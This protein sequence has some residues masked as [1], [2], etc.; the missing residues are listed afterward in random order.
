VQLFNSTVLDN[1]TLFDDT[2]ESA[3]VMSVLDDVGLAPWLA[4][5]PDGLETVIGTGGV[6]MSAGEAQLL[7]LSRAFLADPA[8]VVLD[9]PSSRLDPATE[10]LVEA[11]T[12]RL[13]AGRT[14]IVIAHRLAAL[15]TVDDVAVLDHGRVVEHG[16]RAVLAADPTS[17][18]S[19]LLDPAKSSR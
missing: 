19:Q 5:L 1:V 16:P 3:R 15:A 14:A 13:L 9:E 11:A 10:A 18:F 2:V 7:A 12:A 6:G 17:V 8:V 4:T